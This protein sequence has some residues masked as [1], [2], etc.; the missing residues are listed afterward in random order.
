LDTVRKERYHLDAPFLIQVYL[1]SKF[2]P[3]LGTVGL[4]VHAPY[5][6]EFPLF[7]VK[8]VLLDALQLLMLFIFGTKTVSLNHIL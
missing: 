7:K 2:C 3:V 6:R 5:I 1:G 4:R 8:I